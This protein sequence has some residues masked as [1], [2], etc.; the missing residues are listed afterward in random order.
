MITSI[1]SVDWSKGG[2]TLNYAAAKLRTSSTG[3]AIADFIYFLAMN[4]GANVRNIYPVGFSLGGQV[5][6]FVGR[7]VHQMFGI[8]LRAI[9]SLDPALPLFDYGNLDQHINAADAD[10]V[11]VVHTNGGTLGMHNP[12]GHADFYVH[13]GKTQNGCGLDL[14][15]SCSH[16]RAVEYWIEGIKNGTFIGTKC[17]SYASVTKTGCDFLDEQKDMFEEPPRD[18]EGIFYLD[19]NKNSPYALG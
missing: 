17:A 10:Y 19:T 6:G 9:L 7:N 14:F 16:V 13:G 4:T 12:L 11:Q 1:F 5:V 18:T 15:G 8:K 3:R 2:S